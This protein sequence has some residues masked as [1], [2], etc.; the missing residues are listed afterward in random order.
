MNEDTTTVN[1]LAPLPAPPVAVAVFAARRKHLRVAVCPACWW[2]TPGE[3]APQTAVLARQEHERSC[4]GAPPA[5][6]PR[7]QLDA[8]RRLYR[9]FVG[10][11]A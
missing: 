3:V 2:G 11:P 7:A 8:A 4:P 10:A 9:K 6:V 5:N 1:L